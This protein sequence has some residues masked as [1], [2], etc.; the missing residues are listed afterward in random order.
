MAHRELKD[1]DRVRIVDKGEFHGYNAVVIDADGI[2]A[3]VQT[4]NGENAVCKWYLASDLI[5]RHSECEYIFDGQ[6]DADAHERFKAE[7]S[8]RLDMLHEYDEEDEDP[9]QMF[10]D[11]DMEDT[12]ALYFK[13]ERLEE[14][15][16][17]LKQV[18]KMLQGAC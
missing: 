17:R 4:H 11:M 9:D 8:N 13:C 15:N 2:S 10:L 5:I 16:E 14:E 1:L 3:K 18:I 6:Y 7:M 12:K